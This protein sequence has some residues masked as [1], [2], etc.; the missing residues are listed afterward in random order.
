M[1]H[2]WNLANCASSTDLH[3]PFR[4]DVITQPTGVPYKVAKSPSSISLGLVFLV[5]KQQVGKMGDAA[6]QLIIQMVI[7]V[8][9]ITNLQIPHQV[10]SDIR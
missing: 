8:C 6:L 1:S 4:D 10:T 2:F 9:C 5:S 3:G 7:V